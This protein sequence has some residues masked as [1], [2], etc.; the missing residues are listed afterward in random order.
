[1]DEK[2][3]KLLKMCNTEDFIDAI[4]YLSDIDHYSEVFNTFLKVLFRLKFDKLT[5][6]SLKATTKVQNFE[7]ELTKLEKKFEEKYGPGFSIYWKCVDIDD[8][9]AYHILSEDKRRAVKEEKQAWDKEEKFYK[10]LQS[11]GE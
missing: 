1:M 7:I 2:N 9:L 11:K 6:E 5:N 8:R 10:L 3:T 4:E